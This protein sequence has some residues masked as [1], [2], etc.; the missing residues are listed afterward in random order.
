[1]KKIK[2]KLAGADQLGSA[3]ELNYKRVTS[4]GTVIGGIISILVTLA[5]TLFTIAQFATI[6]YNPQYNQTYST[7]VDRT[8]EEMD[9]LEGMPLF[10]F[11]GGIDLYEIR[12]SS[13]GDLRPCPEVLTKHGVAASQVEKMSVPSNDYIAFGR[14]NL[15]AYY[16]LDTKAIVV[17]VIGSHG[18]Y[19]KPRDSEVTDLI[20]WVSYMSRQFDTKSY[21]GDNDSMEYSLWQQHLLTFEPGKWKI[22]TITIE[23]TY[24]ELF[25]NWVFDTSAL[26]S[27]FEN[28]GKS[29]R[30]TK[31]SPTHDTVTYE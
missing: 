19:I 6:K 24:T 16:C 23:F 31:L 30:T 4:Y 18:V 12:Y 29:I 22:A 8:G 26:S 9:I 1:M 10:F 25:D 20:V 7:K 3:T 28:M 15:D 11:K 2:S 17:D 27:L 13:W 5:I 21:D 14:L